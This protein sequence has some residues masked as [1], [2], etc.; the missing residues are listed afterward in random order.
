MK[1]FLL[2]LCSLLAAIVSVAQNAPKEIALTAEEREQ[3]VSNNNFAFNLFRE[4]REDESLVLSPLSIT[5]ALGMLNNGAAGQTL[6]EINSVLGFTDADATNTFC[7]K[8]LDESGKVDKETKVL[9]AN[10]IYVN[11]A[12]GYRLLTPFVEKA[13]SYYDAQPETRD[14]NDGQTMDVINQWASDHTEGMITKVLNKDSFDPGAISYLLNAICFKGTWSMPFIPDF[15]KPETFY[16]YGKNTDVQMMRQWETFDYAENDLCQSVRLPYGNG[17]YEMT[18]FLPLKGKTL[19]DLLGGMN[20][21]NWLSM[22]YDLCNLSLALPRFETSIDVD[23]KPIMSALG[24]PSAFDMFEA[25]FP[26]FCG[27]ELDPHHPIFI[28][29]MKQVARI[30]VDEEGTEAAAVTVIGAKD[31]AVALD[32][33]SFE[34]NRP[35][36]F[37]ISERSTGVIFFIGQY[38]G[39]DKISALGESP[40]PISAPKAEKAR[41]KY[42]YDLQGRKT[43]NS[44][45]KKGV[46]IIDGKKVVK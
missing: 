24:M 16:G 9:I 19:D 20:G 3:V 38:M 1:R 22:N 42:A 39:A 35:F 32:P 4:A 21:S 13:N 26:D 10:T 30:K 14:F 15:T 12:R 31:N 11:E 2:Y 23:L 40:T 5:Y 25:E 6:Q 17:G 41:N 46:Y 7:R 34:A 43:E 28:D 8:M 36:L 45:M 27:N 33:I 29:L 44:E 37:T 18:V